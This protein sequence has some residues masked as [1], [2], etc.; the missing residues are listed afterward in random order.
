MRTAAATGNCT[1]PV[2][3]V[4]DSIRIEALYFSI[5]PPTHNVVGAEGA[6]WA[7]A[8]DVTPS[9]CRVGNGACLKAATPDATTPDKSRADNCLLITNASPGAV[10]GC[11]FK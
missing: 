2:A 1:V 9:I 10:V 3:V 8:S 4:N 5:V 6:D 7:S 11:Y